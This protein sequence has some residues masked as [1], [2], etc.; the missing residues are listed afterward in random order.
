MALYVYPDRPCTCILGPGLA[1]VW[2]SGR[3]AVVCNFVKKLYAS[4]EGEGE[5]WEADLTCIAGSASTIVTEAARRASRSSSAR[6][7]AQTVC[8]VTGV[9]ITEMKMRLVSR[10]RLRR[11]GGAKRPLSGPAR[12]LIRVWL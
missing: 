6:R 7:H 11:P 10:T 5:V 3:L 12:R 9:V 2:A 4:R 8:V 1:E